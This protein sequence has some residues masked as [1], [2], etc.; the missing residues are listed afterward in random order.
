MDFVDVWSSRVLED[1]GPD[2]DGPP[3]KD[4]DEPPP[5]DDEP[6]DDAPDGDLT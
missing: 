2:A 3:P 6:D 1:D 4:D 5:E